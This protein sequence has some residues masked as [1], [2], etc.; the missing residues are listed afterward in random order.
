MYPA[1]SVSVHPAVETQVAE[2]SAFVS[3]LTVTG[4]EDFDLSFGLMI[5]HCF[6]IGSIL[7]LA[8]FLQRQ[9]SWGVGN[10]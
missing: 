8:S 9:L 10:H 6:A 3:I 4:G 5:F 2:I 7:F 1:F